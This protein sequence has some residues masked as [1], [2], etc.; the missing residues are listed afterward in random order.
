MPDYLQIILL[1]QPSLQMAAFVSCLRSKLDKPVELLRD[2]DKLDK[3]PGRTNT[4]FLADTDSLEA[5]EQGKLKRKLA[6]LKFDFHVALINIDDDTPIEN[7]AFTILDTETTGTNPG[8][9][10]EIIEIGMAHYSGRKV[11]DTFETL[12]RP[13]HPLTREAKEI[14]GIP[15]YRAQVARLAPAAARPYSRPSARPAKR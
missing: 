12:I 2:H 4:L 6:Q 9:G 10:H 8:E 5:A 15:P 13:T 1:S 7:I 14:H 3:L 11:R